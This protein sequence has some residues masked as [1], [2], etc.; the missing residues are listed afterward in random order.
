MGVKQGYSALRKGRVS[1]DGQVYLVTFVTRQRQPVFGDFAVARIAARTLSNRDFW[2]GSEILC[3]VLMPD[4]W[5]GLIR[6]RDGD[7]LCRCVNR[8]KSA[9]ALRV[10]RASERTGALWQSGFHDHALRHNEDLEGVAR[11]IVANPLRA[12]LVSKIGEYPFWDA[13][14]L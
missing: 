1:I 6:L 11:Y 12:G 9:S 14:W 3:W 2:L 8:A 5:H 13:I 7:I 4:H 10:N